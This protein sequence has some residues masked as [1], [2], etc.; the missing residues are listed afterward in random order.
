MIEGSRKDIGAIIR[1]GTEIESDPVLE[2][3]QGHLA[4]EASIHRSSGAPWGAERPSAESREVAPD[5]VLDFDAAGVLVGIDIDHA[6]QH[7]ELSR[8]ETHSLPAKTIPQ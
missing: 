1:D 4:A 6:S 2:Q 7:F 3:G 5:V 8:L